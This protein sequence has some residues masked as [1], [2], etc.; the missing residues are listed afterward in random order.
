[1]I[2]EIKHGIYGKQPKLP[3]HDLISFN[4]KTLCPFSVLDLNTYSHNLTMKVVA[5]NDK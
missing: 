2:I 3:L 5:E 4:Y 1:M